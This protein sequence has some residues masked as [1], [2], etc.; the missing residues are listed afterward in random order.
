MA[1]AATG[2]L[3]GVADRRVVTAAR[4]IGGVPVASTVCASEGLVSV[5]VQPV[6]ERYTSVA[7][8]VVLPLGLDPSSAAVLE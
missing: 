2:A 4:P 8:A 1:A 7:P 6:G 5:A 3:S